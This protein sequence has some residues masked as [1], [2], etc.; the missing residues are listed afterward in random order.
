MRFFPVVLC[1]LALASVTGALPRAAHAQQSAAILAT[2][3]ADGVSASHA[4][5]LGRMVRARL[6]GLD[7]VQTTSG[8][9]LD[10][11][12]VQLALGCVGE[13]AECLTPVAE[14]LDVRFL[15]IPHLDGGQGEL[16]LTL[17][18]FDRQEAAIARVVRR[19][20]HPALLDAVDGQLRELFGLPAAIAP[21]PGPDPDPDPDPT[22]VPP[23]SSGPSAGPFVLMG[24]GAVAIGVGVGFG[25]AFLG[26]DDEYANADPRSAAE[27]RAANEAYA[28][29]ET[30]AIT[31]DVS[32]I[33]G[34]A[35]AAA[36]LAWLLVELVAGGETEGTSVVP[37]LGPNVAGLQLEETF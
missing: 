3:A 1:A 10:L 9:A 14:E 16:M 6:D 25:V 18:L 5:S 17:T 22:P 26:A 28:R 34:G 31:A 2:Q 11:S 23:P 37:L 32:L 27:A 33:A 13:S 4:E 20:D 7:V 8:V 15:L 29:A 12:E 35:I 19:G 21:D 36:G 30:Y 24:V